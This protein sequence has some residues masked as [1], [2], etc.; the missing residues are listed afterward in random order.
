MLF[1]WFKLAKMLSYI[2]YMRL[3]AKQAIISPHSVDGSG[4]AS[5]N[6][7]VA[8]NIIYMSN[9]QETAHFI[10]TSQNKLLRSNFSSY[11]G[12]SAPGSPTWLSHW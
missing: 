12:A 8:Q 10:L 6:L 3:T 9:L 2:V 5:K 7:M 4:E 11:H 1:Y